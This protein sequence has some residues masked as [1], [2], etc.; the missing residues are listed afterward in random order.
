[1]KIK[2]KFLILLMAILI[3]SFLVVPNFTNAAS[4]SKNFGIT[5]MRTN[6]TPNMGY[7]IEDPSEGTTGSAAYIYNIIEYQSASS[8]SIVNSNNI[9][10]AKAEIGFNGSRQRA[11]YDVF[12]NMKTERDE[13]KAQ[14]TTLASIVDGT[15]PYQ[16]GTVSKYDALLALGDLLYLIDKDHPTES[17]NKKEALLNAAGINIDDY[18]KT[19]TDDD[20]SVIQQVAIWY[21]TNYGENNGKFDKSNATME[22]WLNYTL[23][24][25]TY[26]T[27]ANYDLYNT[28][29]GKE[30]VEQAQILYDYL[31]NTAKAN[32]H[33][34]SDSSTQGVPVTVTTTSNCEES[35][36]NYIV[37]PIKITDNGTGIPYTIGSLTVKRNETV[38]TNYKL[39]DSNKAETSKTLTQLVGENFYISVPKDGTNKVEISSNIGYTTSNLTLWASTTNNLEQP[40]MIPEV[41]QEN[42]PLSLTVTPDRAFDLALR[43]YIT[44]VNGVELTDTRVPTID[45]ST[46]T[47]GTTATY[48]HRKDPVTI[49]KNDKITYKITVYNEGQKVGRATKIVDQL[50][51]GLKFTQVVSGN[52]ELGSYD[53]SG[54]NTLVL[55]RKA[56]NTDNLPAYSTG[57]LQTNGN[58]YETIEIECEVT[59]SPDRTNSKILT[60]VAYISEAYDADGNITIT[61]QTGA[62]RDSEPGTTPSV[63]KDNMSD[64]KGNNSNKDTL[65]DT[66]YYYKGQQDDDDFEKL[67]LLPESFDLKLIKRITA[68]NNNAVTERIQSIDTSKLNRLDDSE[69]MVTTADYKLSKE[70]VAVRKGDI[71]T[72]TFRIYNEGTINGYASEITE[73]IPAGLEFLWSEKEGSELQA[74]TSLTEAEKEAIEFNQARY[75]VYT[76]TN[77]NKIKTDYLSKDKESTTGANLITAFG[78]NDGTKTF[79]EANYKEIA[80]KMK[81]T[82]NDISQTPI[83][84][85]AWISNDTDESGNP[86]DDRDSDPETPKPHPDHEDDEDHDYIILKSFDLAL[87]KFIV[88]V[89]KDTTIESSE[90]L[91]NSDGSYTRAPQVDTSKLNTSENGKLIT[92]ATYNHSKKPVEVSKGDIVVYNL[93]VYNEGNV[94]GYA[95]EIIDHLPSNLEFVNGTFNTGYG[96]TEV[97]GSNGRAYKTEYLKNT[98]IDS[99]TIDSDGKVTQLA[100][101]EKGANGKELLIMCKVKDTAPTDEKITN[102]ADITKYIDEDGTTVLTEDRDS[103]P[104]NVDA[105]EGNKP[106]YKDNES[107]NYIPGQQD[108]DDFEKI[109]VPKIVDLALTK[110]ITAIST[111][112]NIEDGEYLTADK[113]GTNA[114]SSSNPYTRQTAVN[115]TELRDNPTCHDAQY[116]QVKTPLVVGNNSYVLYNIRVYNEGE[117]D[118]YAG[119][120]TDYLPDYLTFVEGEFNT[121]YGWSADGQTVKT[122]YLSSKNGTDK[123]LKAFDKTSDNGAGSGLDYKDLQILCRVNSTAPSGRELINTAEIT[124]YEDKD[125]NE[126]PKDVDS[127]PDNVKTKNNKDREEDDDDYEVVLVQNVDLALTKFITAISSDDKIEDGEYLTADKTGT[128]AGSSSNPYTRQTKVDTTPL[129]DGT[130]TDAI[131]TRVKDSLIINRNSYVLYNIRVYNEGTVDV[132]AGEVTDYLPENLS[133]V[134]GEFNSKYGWT[135]DGQIVKTKYLSSSNGTDKIL[136]AFDVQNDDNAG[137]GLDYKDL[138]ILCQV[139]SGTPA[140]KK[141]INTAEITKYENKDG[142]EIPNDVDSTPDNVNPKNEEKRQEDDDDYEVVEVKEFDLALRKWVTQAIIT[143]N[144]QQRVVNTGHE[145][146]DDPEAAVKV[147]LNKKLLN[148]TTVKFRYSIR[149]INEGDIAGYAKEITDYIPVGLKFVPADNPGWTAEGENVVSTRLLENE[150][151]QPGEY[152]D[153]SILL[154]WQ[155]S[156]N[157]MGLKTNTAEI[158]EDYN[159]Y[160]VP[161]KDSIPDNEKPGEDDIDDAPVLLSI[162]T[163]QIRIYFTLGLVI[164]ITLA[165]GISLIKKYVL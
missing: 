13:I 26:D 43:K 64:Y 14:N 136:K 115:T 58:G 137:S 138:P 92:T 134:E 113:T 41:V 75:W 73:D 86:I 98:K 159:E 40:I 131:Y 72:Y 100:T 61:N 23:D 103:E 143:E 55:N 101:N 62:D 71:V 160:G 124:K 52:F 149:V 102:I 47:G 8:D 57:S 95:G 31:I 152:K 157:N 123:I 165:G 80:V 35:G 78:T 130:S 45:E 132:Y 158:S 145:P 69:N 30:R 17:Q 142:E 4:G 10:C 87:R 1:M 96:W 11:T 135:A 97:E 12:Y 151:L 19:L 110:F 82:S 126:L 49:N 33:N 54:N 116:T 37:G 36:S 147:E 150:L 84:N 106:E 107:G 140:N 24:G 139:N 27:L 9:Y 3:A 117:V 112:I 38:T 146:Y 77:L 48:K 108:D 161:D 18:N 39:L 32:A 122:S 163:G 76:D 81:V 99:A 153:I 109:I 59:A 89:S 104:N 63:N 67:V 88:A 105:T 155:N 90:Y 28:A 156:E 56:S 111:D 46:L 144:G 162:K 128:N 7:A 93:R 66:D 85:E 6:D 118:V 53:E 60:N 164:L 15:V 50:P 44:K 91:K 65:N 5:I 114:G 94:D 154:T 34:Y 68:V 70:P 119:E 42:I 83:K 141:L 120:V 22:Q 20:I 21:F 129:K 127:T 51:T 133:F 121:K 79:T 16:S 148:S 125:G 25:S 29:E 74:D 2:N